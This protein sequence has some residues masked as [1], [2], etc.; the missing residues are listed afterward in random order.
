[1][2][3]IR[4]VTLF[5]GGTDPGSGDSDWND[6]YESGRVVVTYLHVKV[7]GIVFSRFLS[8]AVCVW[9]TRPVPK[10]LL[11]VSQAEVHWA[12]AHV[13]N[14]GAICIHGKASGFWKARFLQRFKVQV[15]KMSLVQS[16]F[17][18][19]HKYFIFI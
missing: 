8:F 16:A 13:I 12:V 6:F 7:H 15:G 3:A 14:C 5:A 9:P 18:E 11:W 2:I 17:F 10:F 1:M 19:F 4:V